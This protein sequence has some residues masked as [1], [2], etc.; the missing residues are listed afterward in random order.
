MTSTSQ[1]LNQLKDRLAKYNKKGSF[2]AG[3]S[4]SI[5]MLTLLKSTSGLPVYM[6]K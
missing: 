6:C 3:L 5:G 2:L 4:V 1:D